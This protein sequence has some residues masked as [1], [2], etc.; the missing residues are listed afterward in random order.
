[1]NPQGTPADRRCGDLAVHSSERHE[2][3]ALAGSRA[4]RHRSPF[5]SSRC[6]AQPAS[7][8]ESSPRSARQ[9]GSA[10]S[11]GRVSNIKLDPSDDRLHFVSSSLPVWPESRHQINSGDGRDDAH[12]TPDEERDLGPS[13]H[14]S[15][16]SG[17]KIP[18]SNA[19][20][21][22]AFDATAVGTF[23]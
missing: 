10:H 19:A 13:A 1:V 11:I 7:E 18:S 22:P 6:R 5:N 14:Q 20:P 3:P 23:R 12:P 15:R 4:T 16:G 21:Q 2:G 9:T 17:P 8:Q